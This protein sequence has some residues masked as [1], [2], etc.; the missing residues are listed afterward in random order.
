MWQT[1][2]ITKNKNKVLQLDILWVKD[3]WMSS[4]NSAVSF[5]TCVGYS[6]CWTLKP[7][8][9]GIYQH[10]AKITRYWKS[11]DLLASW[12]IVKWCRCW[13]YNGSDWLIR[14]LDDLWWYNGDVFTTTSCEHNSIIIDCHRMTS[15]WYHQIWI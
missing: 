1:V 2:E 6:W 9:Q 7:G 13:I 5:K 15:T 12:F 11:W 3:Y 4:F 14:T 8:G 10:P